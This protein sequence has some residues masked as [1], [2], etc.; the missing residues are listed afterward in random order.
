M[1]WLSKLFLHSVARKKHFCKIPC[2]LKDTSPIHLINHTWE[3]P[4]FLHQLLRGPSAICLE[5]ISDDRYAQVVR[6]I[7]SYDS[8][9]VINDSQIE[10]Y[11]FC[12]FN[13]FSIVLLSIY[14][15]L[16]KYC[17]KKRKSGYNSVNW[18]MSSWNSAAIQNATGKIC[19]SREELFLMH[20]FVIRLLCRS[21]QLMGY[22]HLLQNTSIY[23]K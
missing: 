8:D 4:D 17:I 12:R 7:L 20:L 22:H 23:C 16:N 1:R 6:W 18:N 9:F 14:N 15:I 5:M 10:K 11:M 13:V 19:P 2:T 21:N 3:M